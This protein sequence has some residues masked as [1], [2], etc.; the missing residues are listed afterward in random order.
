MIIM[1]DDRDIHV[2]MFK[3]KM[4]SEIENI[5]KIIYV[6]YSSYQYEFSSFH[7]Y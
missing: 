1:V 2:Q 5:N 7:F 4:M 6:S 3:I